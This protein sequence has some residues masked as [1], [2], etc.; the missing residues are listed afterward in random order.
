MAKPGRKQGKAPPRANDPRPL[1]NTKHE[2]FAQKVAKGAS[3]SAAYAELYGVDRADQVTRS[4]ASE[5]R[6]LPIVAARIEELQREAAEKA[7]VEIAEVIRELRLLA[8]ADLGGAFKQDGTLENPA[9]MPEAVRRALAGFEVVE[10]FEGSGRDRLQIGYT[11]KVKFW[12]K[13]KALELLGKYL[14]MWTDKVELGGKLT[15]EQLVAGYE[16]D[17]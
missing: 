16:D 15:L 12:E 5:L 13:T 17:E 4:S 14:K 9:D 8:F 11:K 10:E 6:S 7:T 2:L 3:Y 1:Q